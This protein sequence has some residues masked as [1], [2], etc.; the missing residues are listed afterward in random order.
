MS[1]EI[2]APIRKRTKLLDMSKINEFHLDLAEIN[3]DLIIKILKKQPFERTLQDY[4]ILNDYIL[5]LSKLSDKFK[6]Q[7]IPQNLFEK[8]ILLSLQSCKLKVYLASNSSIYTPETDANYIYIVLKGSVKITKIQKQLIKIK[9]FDYFHLLINLRD[10][11]EDYF[12]KNTINENRNVFPVDYSEMDFLDKILLKILII[13]RKEEKNDYTYLDKLMKKVGLKYEIFGL[14]GSYKDELAKK[15]EEIQKINEELIKEERGFECKK[16][17]PYK[18]EE[19]IEYEMKQEKKINEELNFI[20]YDIYQKYMYFTLD[21]EEFIS[22]FELMEDKIVSNNEYFGDYFGNKYVDFAKAAEDN[23]Y[24]LMIKNNMINQILEGAKDKVISKQV[25]FLVNNFFFNSINKVVFEKY[26][27]NCFELENYQSGQK[28]CDE[29]ESVKYLYFIKKGKVKLSYKKSILEIHSLINIIKEQ[30]KEKRFDETDYNSNKIIKF[31][32]NYQDY[33]DLKGNVDSIKSEL[34]NKQEKNLMIYQENQCIGYESYYYGLKYLYTASAISDNVEIYKISLPQLIR[35]FNNKNELCYVEL[36]K[37]AEECLFLF[38]KRLIKMNNILM[39]FF[40]KRKVV[41]ETEK[42]QQINRNEPSKILDQNNFIKKKSMPLKKTEI[43]KIIPSLIKKANNIKS[44]NNSFIFNYN[45][46]SLLYRNL[47]PLN[48]FSDSTMKSEHEKNYLNNSSQLPNIERREKYNI[49]KNELLEKKINSNHNIKNKKLFIT[50]SRVNID[51]NNKINENTINSSLNNNSKYF[52]ESVHSNFS[53]I[54]LRNSNFS[55][56]LNFNG[57][58]SYKKGEINLS[59]L[60]DKGGLTNKSAMYPLE[61]KK[62]FLGDKLRKFINI[63]KK[64]IL[65]KNQIYKF[66]KDRLNYMINNF[67]FEG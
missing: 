58:E 4:S 23:L 19:E 49:L 50:S 47:P 30:I 32:K 9:P 46:S 62:K 36:S 57:D 27:L 21:K 15:N 8:I 7:R 56:E 18:R 10:K 38:M 12:L 17:I 14:K 28:I 48:N 54:P 42:N 26:Y 61:P 29:N 39:N 13:N 25:D 53:C 55:K 35:L 33:Y 63:K 64:L 51:K 37:K 11:K 41:E 6:N 34:N 52:K 22:K 16:L 3:N 40:E 20:N 43:S 45:E 65:K 5:F 31:L 44:T 59:K 24:L 1:D 60:L 66:Q 2:G 67:S